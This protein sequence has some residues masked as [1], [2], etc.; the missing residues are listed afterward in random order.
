MRRRPVPADSLESCRA[1]I[2]EAAGQEAA[3]G[4]AGAAQDL[5]RH[6]RLVL[7]ARENAGRRASSRLRSM[8]G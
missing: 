3:E 6:F 8:R 1:I 7:A 4:V 5:G 2:I